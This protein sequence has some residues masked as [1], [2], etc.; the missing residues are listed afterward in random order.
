MSDYFFK[1]YKNEIQ[2]RLKDNK[3]DTEKIKF[4]VG[5]NLLDLNIWL[6]NGG[7]FYQSR[8]L[9]RRPA[10][11]LGEKSHAEKK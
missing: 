7:A 8:H 5:S 4:D 1:H 3:N 11:T 9:F 10:R 2:N 6:Q